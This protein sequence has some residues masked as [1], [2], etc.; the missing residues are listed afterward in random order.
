MAKIRIGISGWT[1]EPWRKTFYP[2]G[3]TQKRELEYASRKVNAIE[4]NGTFY[5][6]QKPKS[7]ETWYEQTPDDFSFA[8][9]GPKYITHERRL[10]DVKTPLANFLASG[11]LCLKQKL[12][13]I[14]WQFPPG[15]P[16]LPDRFEEFMAMLPHDTIAAADLSKNHSDWMKDRCVT[17]A[18]VARPMRH[19]I[20]VRHE[21]FK[22]ASFIALL[23][24]YNVAAV[25]GDT[26]GRWPYIE[27]VT[28]DFVY[29]RL[30][31]DETVYPEGYTSKSLDLWADRIAT[32]ARGDE[33]LDAK[34]VASETAPKAPRDVFA[35]ADNDTKDR[36]PF[37]AMALWKR[38]GGTPLEDPAVDDGSSSAKKKVT[39]KKTAKKK[40]AA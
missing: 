18:D 19:A 8:I 27:D 14:L 9:K 17:E 32:W 35:F 5:A 22:D 24:R 33:P 31:G 6:L 21:S 28:S 23:R 15:L 10:K 36:A 1:Y 12:G 13:P 25:V 34:R 7:Y 2:D 40:K 3:L 38:L 39:K 37:D 20:E 4:V 26:A 16:F 29:I 11:I 30:H